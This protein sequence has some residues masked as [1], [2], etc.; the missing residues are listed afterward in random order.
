MKLSVG[1]LSGG[2]SSRMG[3]NK[4]FLKIGR[5]SFLDIIADELSCFDELIVSVDCLNK[6][7]NLKYKLVSDSI[8]N[9]GPIEGIYQIIKNAQNQYIFICATDMPFLKK[10]LVEYMK[11]FICSDFDC[12]T[13]YDEN[14]LHPLC[15][16]YSKNV[17]PIIQNMINNKNYK[18]KELLLNIKT[19][20]INLNYTKFNEKIICNVNTFE[21]YKNIMKPIIFCV[22]GL[23]N[24]GKT[25]LIVRLIEEFSKEFKK[26]GVIKHDGHDFVIDYEETDTDKFFKS[27]AVKV[28]IFSKKKYA[29]ICKDNLNIEKVINYMNDMDMIIIEGMKNSNYPK[30]EIVRK[31]ISNKSVCKSDFLIAIASDADM[32]NIN[33]ASVIDL[34]DTEAISKAIL[35]Y[36]FEFDWR[37]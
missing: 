27:N 3:Y 2:K 28:C 37:K 22:S 7:E 10:E 36:F 19:K 16:I 25:G 23:K 13:V 29:L 17:I 34:N 30:I 26:I 8:K 14:R 18:L 15:A 31:E 4:A 35:N 9:I 11:S 12:Y 24:T 6:Y 21:E 32:E 1:I 33:T 5:K 20:Y